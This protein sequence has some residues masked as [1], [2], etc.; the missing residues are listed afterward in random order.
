MALRPAAGFGG[1]D[2][3]YISKCTVPAHQKK[4]LLQPPPLAASPGEL[5]LWRKQNGLLNNDEKRADDIEHQK[6][7][8]RRIHGE[9]AA[10]AYRP[11]G[12]PVL[13]I[14]AGTGNA[15]PKQHNA[16]RRQSCLPTLSQRA[17][18]AYEAAVAAGAYKRTK[19]GVR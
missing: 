8:T 13:S 19:A 4:Q 17:T 11:M 2:F 7:R 9:A 10:P 12:R 3:T 14:V 1:Q 16:G 5:R 6:A 15:Q 18:A